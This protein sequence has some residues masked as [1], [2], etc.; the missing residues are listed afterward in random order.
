MQGKV[1]STSSAPAVYAGIDVSKAWLDVYVHPVGKHWRVE[2]SLLG[3]RRLH[4]HFAGLE[5][6]P[7]RVVV[8]ATGKFHRQTLRTLSAWGYQVAVVN[9]LRARLFAEAYGTLAK[10]DQLDARM[11]ALMGESLRPAATQ[12]KP[13]TLEELSELVQARS[14]AMAETVALGNRLG[15]AETGFLK[16]EL[17][18]RLKNLKRH[19]DRL[20]AEIGRRIQ[21]DPGLRDRFAILVS[22]PGIGPTVAAVLLVGL[23]EMGQGSGKAMTLL[24]GLAPLADDSGIRHGQ[25]HIRGGRMLVR[26]ALYMAAL[27]AVRYNADLKAVY[28]RLRDKGKAAKLALTAVMRKLVVLAN[29]LITSNRTWTPIPPKSA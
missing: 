18:R 1:V 7:E 24:A 17:S 21:L 6:P 22:I 23:S 26:N 3:L 27:S 2:N 11:L 9:P 13:Q 25:R 19:L 12:P 14:A 10:T 8:E 5:A 16:A 4:R 15:T 20:E 29:S 28:D